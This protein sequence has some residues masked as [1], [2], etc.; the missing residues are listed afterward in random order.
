VLSA[1][2]SGLTLTPAERVAI[3][4][5]VESALLNEGDGQTLLQAIV[6]TIE[7]QTD[8]EALTLV[9]IKAQVAAALTE[10]TAAKV[11]DVQVTV[12]GG[13]EAAD[14]TALA[15]KA[16]STELTNAVNA[17][18]GADDKDLS[19]VYANTPEIELGTMPNDILD[20]KASTDT[21]Q[22]QVAAALAAYDV[23][24]VADVSL[25]GGGGGLTTAQA[26]KLESIPSNPVLT[27]DARLD[28]LDASISG[29][30][31]TAD[32]AA[33]VTAIKGQDNKDLTQVFD[34]TPQVDLGTLP[35]DVTAIKA[36]TD[37]TQAQVTAALT[38]YEAAKA[39]DVQVTV[40]ADSN[41]T[42]PSA[43]S[44]ELSLS[45][46]SLSYEVSK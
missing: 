41:A 14:R 20:I 32:V 9:A 42:A 18:K 38:V 28:N 16:T 23:A 27:D 8:I 36:S 35:A 1:I 43:V 40:S 25:G 5:A 44:L 6:D 46:D 12:S 3:A 21:T 45:T 29:R 34:N 19:Q 2:T 30:A 39:S 17:I 22:D 24:K 15:A 10:Y 33:A 26:A 37:T 11:S 4:T 13:F 7:A 31:T